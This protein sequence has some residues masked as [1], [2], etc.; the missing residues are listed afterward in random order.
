M[1]RSP[2]SR[3]SRRAFTLIELAI[4][5]LI[6]GILAGVAAPKYADALARFRV[7]AAAKRVA[8]DMRYARSR[9]IERSE[10]QT[11][12]FFPTTERYSF[13]NALHPTRGRTGYHVDLIDEGFEVDLVSANFGGAESMSFDHRGEASVAGAITLT[14]GGYTR[15]ISV[16]LPH[17]ITVG[18]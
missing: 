5:L 6:L 8:I 11:V 14:S 15:T 4:V 10:T 3:A 2:K 7:E 9:A 17:Q 18:P 1:M 12:E 13:A 16:S